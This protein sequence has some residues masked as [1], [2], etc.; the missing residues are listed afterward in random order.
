MDQTIITEIFST[1]W[2]HFLLAKLWNGFAAGLIGTS[3]LSYASE[4]AMPQMRGTVLA[5]YAF[6]FAFG[7]LACAIA[8]DIINRVSRDQQEMS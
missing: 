7:Q 6:F 4:I 8:L 1:T 5:S 2:W 3:V